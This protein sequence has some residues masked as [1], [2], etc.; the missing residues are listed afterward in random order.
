MLSAEDVIRI[1]DLKPHPEG[2][3]Y[4]EIYRSGELFSQE[5]LPPRYSAPP[6]LRHRHLLLADIQRQIGHAQG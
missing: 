4:K 5:S 6:L 3:Y 1:L 2:G